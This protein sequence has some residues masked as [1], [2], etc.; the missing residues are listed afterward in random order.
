M[1]VI[2]I[3]FFPILIFVG[4]CIVMFVPIISAL[5]CEVVIVSMCSFWPSEAEANWFTTWERAV[6]VRESRQK[7]IAATRDLSRRVLHNPFSA[8]V[9]ARAWHEL[10]DPIRYVRRGSPPAV[11]NI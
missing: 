2:L 5:A 9:W 1:I 8:D 7:R 11:K 4:V 6:E 3:L 10:Q